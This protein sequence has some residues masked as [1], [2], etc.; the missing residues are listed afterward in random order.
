MSKKENSLN[1]RNVSYSMDYKLRFFKSP[2]VWLCTVGLIGLLIRIYFFPFEIPFT[3]DTLDYFGYAVLTNQLGQIPPEWPLANNG[4][5]IFVST[6]FT[7]SPENFFDYTYIQRFTSVIIS[8]LTI[9]PVYFLCKK[10]FNKTLS[11][12][13]SALFIFEPRILLNSVSGDTMSIFILLTTTTILLFIQKNDKLIFCAFVIA[14]LATLIRYEAL[15]LIIPLS[16]MFF[17]KREH[18]NKKIIKYFSGLGIFILI[19]IPLSYVGLESS[20]SDGLMSHYNAG[21]MYI[22]S[23]V[24]EGISYSEPGNLEIM[25]ESWIKPNQNNLQ[26][27][28]SNIIENLSW[29]SA[30]I[31]IPTFIFFIPI[32]IFIIFKEKYFKKID[33]GV[34]SIIIF[35]LFLLVPAFYAYGRNLEE[36]RYLFVIFPMLSMVSLI[37]INKIQEKIDKKYLTTIL[38]ISFILF[39]SIIGLNSKNLDVEYE[40]Q[41]EIFHIVKFIV[42]NAEGINYFTPESQFVKSAEVSEN[43]PNIPPRDP[44]GLGHLTRDLELF[45][46]S[47]YTSLEKFIVD[48]KDDGLTHIIVDGV[49][50]RN[51]IVNDVFFNENEYIY[52][53]K[54]YDS[55]DYDFKYH[56]KIFQI[57]HKLLENLSP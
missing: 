35:S 33:H 11:L 32:S 43:W 54:I 25:D 10:F 51:Q 13:G 8:V 39:L 44:W 27:F 1:K 36:S 55:N 12:I 20:G 6:L 31:M 9:I 22:T 45:E 4:W 53:D 38:L 47:G 2:V 28:L 23:E 40:H 17:I 49:Y 48:H 41:R 46:T 16:I 56:V 26:K 5:P 57:N 3:L 29:F 30:W 52:L 15:V 42:N 14:A 19:L 37:F 50:G 21:T 18:T 7:F 34:L 24:I